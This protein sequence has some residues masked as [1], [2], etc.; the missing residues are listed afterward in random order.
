MAR[1]ELPS[2]A[3]LPSETSLREEFGV[4]RGTIRTALLTLKESG[5]IVSVPSRG[6]Y[7]GGALDPGELTSTAQAG[8]AVSILRMEIQEGKFAQGEQ[9]LSVGELALRFGLTRYTAH[10]ALLELVS[11]GFITPVQ[12]R[13]Y[14]VAA[15]GGEGDSGQ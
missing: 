6:W 10:R 13:G 1:G 3:L 7:V 14:F 9:F 15:P 4:S 2:G 12:S 5:E 8:S 11:L